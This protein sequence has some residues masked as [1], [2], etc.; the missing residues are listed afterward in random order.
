MTKQSYNK[1]NLMGYDVDDIE[2]VQEMNVPAEFAYTKNINEYML[3]V[4]QTENED[5]GMSKAEA[6]AHRIQSEAEI[7]ELYDIHGL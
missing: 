6:R 5:A 2:Y 7:Q 3:D 1:L 4:I